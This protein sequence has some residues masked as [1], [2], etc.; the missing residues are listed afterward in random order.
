MSDA[1]NL[2]QQIADEQ[3]RLERLQ[4]Q[5]KQAEAACE[6]DWTVEN[7]P[8]YHPA[9]TIP[10]DPPGTMGVDWRGPC[11]VD[12]KTTPRW[13]RRCSKCKRVE[14]TT[15]FKQ[16]KKRA[17]IEET[18]GATMVDVTMPDWNCASEGDG[19]HLEPK[20]ERW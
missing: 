6:H 14:Y 8:I 19:S 3:R 15:R 7:R 17:V 1:S 20:K 10:G 13:I 12:S 11:H 5:L 16:E 9:Y 18:G 2:R 4:Q